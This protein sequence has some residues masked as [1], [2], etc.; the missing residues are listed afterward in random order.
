MRGPVVH[1]RLPEAPRHEVLKPE[2]GDPK[3]GTQSKCGGPK[4]TA[5]KA[6]ARKAAA[7]KAAARKR[8]PESDGPK[9]TARKRRPESG[10]L[11][12]TVP[13]GHHARSCAYAAPASPQRVQP[14]SE[15]ATSIHTSF[16]CPAR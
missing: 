4:A 14:D 8:R 15:E 2:G 9:A 1:P 6:A 12:E 3:A 10:S 13:E 16:S 5:R 7:R 11:E